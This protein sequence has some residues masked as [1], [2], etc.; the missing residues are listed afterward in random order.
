MLV[1]LC[2]VTH[3][4]GHPIRN[5]RGAADA[6]RLRLR[7]PSRLL[8]QFIQIAPELLAG[9]AAIANSTNASDLDTL[10]ALLVEPSAKAHVFNS[11]HAEVGAEATVPIR[12]NSQ[13]FLSS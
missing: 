1:G 10:L 7:S 9:T 4:Q 11:G 5:N 8:R 13:Q 2:D 6:P 12:G 3:P